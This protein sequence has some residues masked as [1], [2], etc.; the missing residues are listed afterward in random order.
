MPGPSGQRSSYLRIALR[1]LL[2]D[3]Q[4]A[5]AACVLWLWLELAHPLTLV[6]LLI[7][8]VPA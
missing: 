1:M 7:A 3:S 8:R 4:G 5:L 6:V 2:F